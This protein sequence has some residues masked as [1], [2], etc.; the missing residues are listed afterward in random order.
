MANGPSN[1]FA[2]SRPDIHDFRLTSR[3]RPPDGV[4]ITVR[5]ESRCKQIWRFAPISPTNTISAEAVI[6]CLPCRSDIPANLSVG[7]ISADRQ[8]RIDHNPKEPSTELLVAGRLR[9]AIS[10]ASK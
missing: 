9:S 10:R 5:Q 4:V 2:A 3:C 6:D 8:Y 1:G 7:Q